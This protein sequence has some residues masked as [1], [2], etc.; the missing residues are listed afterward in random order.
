MLG[1]AIGLADQDG[2]VLSG[3]LSL[4]TH[5]WLA[6]HAVQGN[7]LVPGTA[8][9]DLALR[10]GDE[11]GVGVLE[12]LLFETPLILP[13]RGAVAL[14]VAVGAPDETGRRPVAVHSRPQ[15]DD[16]PD[17]GWTRHA[18][19]VFADGDTATAG[20]TVTGGANG[21]GAPDGLAAWPPPG[22][23]R[24]DVPVEEIYGALAAS[25]LAYGPV[26]QGLRSA[27]RA[28]DDLYAEVTLPASHTDE[29]AGFGVHPALL[30]AAVHLSVFHGL[31][32]VPAGHSRL[33]FAWNGVRLHATGPTTLRVRLTVHGPD[34]ISLHAADSTGATVLTVDSLLA[35]LVSA[36]QL[37]A[38]RASR[39]DSLYELSWPSPVLATPGAAS[40]A[41][42]GADAQAAVTAALG[43]ADRQIVVTAPPDLAVLGAA[44]QAGEA[45]PDLVVVAFGGQHGSGPSDA[46]ASASASAEAGGEVAGAARATVERAL[47]LVQDYLGDPRL[48]TTRL[49]VLTSHA[50]SVAGEDVDLAVAPVWGLLRTAQAE[51]P[52]RILLLDTDHEPASAAALPAA[53]ATAEAGDEPSM[54]LRAGT[55]HTPRLTAAATPTATVTVTTAPADTAPADTAADT[56]PAGWNLDPFGTVLITGGLGTLARHLADHLV[57]HHHLRHLHL[58]SRQ[59]PEHPDAA[60]IRGRLEDLGAA[61]TITATDITSRPALDEL[62]AAIPAEHPLTA[63]IHTAGTIDDGALPGLTPARL[64]TVLA[65]KLD[66]AWHLHQATRDL[67]TVRAFVLYSSIAGLTGGPG[68][69]SYTAANSF[70]DALAQHRRAHGLPATS[71]AWGL[72]ADTSTFTA[73]LAAADQRRI[74]RSGLRSLP[75][76]DG[77][78]LFD[79]VGSHDQAAL[80]VPAALDLGALRTR[81]ASDA[82]VPALLRGL[83]RAARPGA[84]RGG[85]AADGGGGAGALV[86]LLADTG[87]EDRPAV[88]L[89]FVRRQAASVL[90]HPGIDTI[91]P[92]RDFGELGLDSLT[93]V[94]LR[95]RLNT[96]TALRLPATLTFDQPNPAA[97]AAYLAEQLTA[98]AAA[99]SAGPASAAAA[100]ARV[101]AV[102]P[103]EGPLAELYLALCAADQFGAAA[104]LLVVA[105]YLRPT[106]DAST[107]GQHAVP[108][109]QLA[110]GPARHRLICF[111]A[112]S[113]VSG[114]HE[115]A[116]LGT[117]L[118]GE[119]DV[120]V[121]PSPG[122]AEDDHLPVDERTYIESHVREVTRLVGDDPFVLVGRSMGGVVAHAVAAELEDAGVAPSGLILIDSYPPESAVREGMADWWLTAMISG[123]LDRV[124]RYQMVW[125]DASLTTMGAYVKIFDGWQA[126]PVQ[127]PTLLVRAAQPLRRTTIDP[128]NPT[129]WQAYWSTPHEA[130][131]VPGEHFSILEE[132]SPTTVAAIREFIETLT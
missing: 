97:L 33:P 23:E 82:P 45:A 3:R 129:G 106:F 21:A 73:E 4:A 110:E 49:A 121:L 55:A 126:K 22:A 88:L 9:V 95:N 10:A 59:G 64:H 89:D 81:A 92:G 19:G 68:Q 62:L 122:Y 26:F 102:G 84:R 65:P 54:A 35:R 43:G 127:T 85:A 111:P 114:P 30:D 103:Q 120:F 15:D 112:M 94:E 48:A 61:V 74:A 93:A 11:L 100:P 69:A 39:Q 117:L 99:E 72:W 2:V 63:V 128:A 44:V 41:A 14:Q 83:V 8:F 5:A 58:I 116:R 76:A 27:W 101:R 96:A 67:P 51:N 31:T 119:R 52:G 56:G 20:E 109:L 91:E 13:A 125:S 80:L 107:A 28:G 86:R 16:A 60:D 123:M 79:A 1:A 118:R 42:V 78:A 47:A 71:L 17:A 77:L 7:V 25:G 38:S 70:L 40:W 105:S 24:V 98:V 50:V 75:A 104:Q 46:S 34:E 87:A 18:S 57:T 12:E 66:G 130:V 132:H 113:A 115:Y 32:D 124:E 29:A 36:E 53:V 131:D 90:G 108:T 6:D 37:A